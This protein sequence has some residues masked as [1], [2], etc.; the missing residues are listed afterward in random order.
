HLCSGR[1]RRAR[2]RRYHRRSRHVRATGV[3]DARAVLRRRRDHGSERIGSANRD[4]P[5]QANQSLRF[6]E[7]AK[8]AKVDETVEGAD[9]TSMKAAKAPKAAEEGIGF[10]IRVTKPGGKPQDYGVIAG[11][12][13]EAVVRV[14]NALNVSNQRVEVYR[15]L[16]N[17]LIRQ[18]RVKP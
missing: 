9:R 12:P 6:I 11:A 10:V 14:S 3:D 7:A 17:G 15:V 5:H 16:T 2:S 18:L 4:E 1:V 8:E 13:E